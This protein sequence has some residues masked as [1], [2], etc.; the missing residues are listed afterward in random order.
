MDSVAITQV[1]DS[2]TRSD[3]STQTNLSSQTTAAVAQSRALDIPRRVPPGWLYIKPA[4]VGH[5][6][7][8]RERDH[9]EELTMMAALGLVWTCLLV[10]A[11]W[12]S[13]GSCDSCFLHIETMHYLKMDCLPFRTCAFVPLCCRLQIE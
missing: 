6:F 4:T 2:N 11:P 7:D 5:S 8:K 12:V 10:L 3:R 1:K 9:P 13:A